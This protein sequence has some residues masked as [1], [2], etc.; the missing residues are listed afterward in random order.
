[1]FD[2]WGDLDY[3]RKWRSVSFECDHIWPYLI[4][5][6]HA[7]RYVHDV[8]CTCSFKSAGWLGRCA[9]SVA[10]LATSRASTQQPSSS[11]WQHFCSL[12]LVWFAAGDMKSERPSKDD[13][14][15]CRCVV[16]EGKPVLQS[17]DVAFSAPS[18]KSSFL[19]VLHSCEGRRRL[20]LLHQGD[21]RG[22]QSEN[23]EDSRLGRVRIIIFDGTCSLLNAEQI[24]MVSRE[25]CVW[26]MCSTTGQGL[27]VCMHAYLRNLLGSAACCW[28]NPCC[29]TAF[30]FFV[31]V[32]KSTLTKPEIESLGFTWLVL[33]GRLA[34]TST[35]CTYMYFRV[36]DK[37]TTAKRK[38]GKL[39]QVLST[40]RQQGRGV[41]YLCRQQHQRRPTEATKKYLQRLLV[42]LAFATPKSALYRRSN[43]FF[44]G[45]R[46]TQKCWQQ[47]PTDL[48]ELTPSRKCLLPPTWWRQ[49]TTGLPSARACSSWKWNHFAGNRA[50]RRG[51]ACVNIDCAR[52]LW[53]I[54]IQMILTFI[55]GINGVGGGGGIWYLQHIAADAQPLSN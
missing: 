20:A 5:D 18:R 29:G 42:L 41:P 52:S 54:H 35:A 13:E 37:F 15:H 28:P 26:A 36:A 51:G 30:I 24:K 17:L 46:P 10:A 49:T 7:Q 6:A 9:S 16:W 2:C 44:W 1:M 40:A 25:A 22:W 27:H 21:S 45:P 38:D 55:C 32:C 3:N 43:F 34:W 33:V 12:L 14:Q 50:G 4:L 23:Q 11:S 31:V 48:D 8:W 39:C 19:R 47:W 53:G